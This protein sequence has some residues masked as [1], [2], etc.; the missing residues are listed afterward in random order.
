MLLLE[1]ERER[2]GE[3]GAERE[4]IKKLH[5]YV[6]S[7][8]SL[9]KTTTPDPIGEIRRNLAEFD[10]LRSSL[11]RRRDDAK[12]FAESH[13]ISEATA[14]L[15]DELPTSLN[16]KEMLAEVDEELI[17]A[18][19]EKSR[20]VLDYNAAL[21]ETEKIDEIE[22]RLYEKNETVEIY[23]DNLRV[24]NRAKD[25]LAAARDSM[26]AKYLDKTRQ[27]FKKYVTLIDEECGEFTM[28]TSFTVSKTDLG[29]SRQAEAYSRGTRDLHSLAIR[30]SLIDALY[31]DEL[32]PLILDDPFIAFDDRHIDRAVSVMKK[33]SDKRQIFYFTC[34]KSRK[35]K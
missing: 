23:L 31:E 14:V 35:A 16:F 25:I 15:P 13:G 17:A 28:D 3:R 29:K 9:F 18:E 10:V 8:L 21:S 22:E 4:K 11:S 6:N 12:R 2:D 32:P 30:L 33:L 1:Y 20:L 7:F 5:E 24:I 26:T 27:G 19:R 34:S